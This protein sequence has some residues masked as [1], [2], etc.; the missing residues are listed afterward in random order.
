MTNAQQKTVDNLYEHY[1]SIMLLPQVSDDLYAVFDLSGGKW[2][3]PSLKQ[4]VILSDGKYDPERETDVAPNS[5]AGR[6]WTSGQ[7]FS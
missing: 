1:G 3:K 4:V 7:S 6:Q 2:S 5:I